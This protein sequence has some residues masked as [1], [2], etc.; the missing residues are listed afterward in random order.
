MNT[1]L[2]AQMMTS[3]GVPRASAE[4]RLKELGIK[5]PTPPEPFAVANSSKF[6]STTT[7]N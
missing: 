4:R 6:F 7:E 2:K 1:N 3:S 5:L